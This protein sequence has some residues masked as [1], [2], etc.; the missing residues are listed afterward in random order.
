M[1]FSHFENLLGFNLGV[2]LLS[3]RRCSGFPVDL[4]NGFGPGFKP[5]TISLHLPRLFLIQELWATLGIFKV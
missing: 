3:R 5:I 1:A 2:F 4:A